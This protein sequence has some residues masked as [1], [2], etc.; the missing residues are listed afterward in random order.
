[1]KTKL[2]IGLIGVIVLLFIALGLTYNRLQ[3]MKLEKTRYETNYEAMKQEESSKAL[4]ER[5]IKDEFKEMFPELK[6]IAEQS[7]IKV[8]NIETIHNVT[9]RT[10]W[11]TVPVEVELVT[12]PLDDQKLSFMESKNC[13]DIGG[14]IDFIKSP[15]LLTAENKEGID[16]IFN[17]V[18]QN[19][20][21]TT[22]FY[23]KRKMKKLF[24][25]FRFIKLRIGKFQVWSETHSACKA[26]IKSRIIQITKKGRK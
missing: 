4:V 5:V 9:H 24:F 22:M 17:K 13:I 3:F 10:V 19:D 2:M 26:E 14:Y 18:E 11:D 8:K 20:T 16:L 15:I 25:P 6:K 7:G 1:M 21:L 12:N 23:K